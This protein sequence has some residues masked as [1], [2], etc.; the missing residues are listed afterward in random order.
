M[1]KVI[2]LGLAMML[3]MIGLLLVGLFT[4]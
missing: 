2:L 4:T 3:G 1:K